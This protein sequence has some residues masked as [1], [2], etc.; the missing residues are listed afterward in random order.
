MD[1]NN[2]QRGRFEPEKTL[3]RVVVSSLLIVVSVS[4]LSV[5]RIATIFAFTGRMSFS[6]SDPTVLFSETNTFICT[7]Y[8]EESKII[9]YHIAGR[10]TEVEVM[11][12]PQIAARVRNHCGKRFY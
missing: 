9:S 10:R 5:N 7:D 2:N 12:L 1:L 3:K 6:P 8:N 11:D 4:F